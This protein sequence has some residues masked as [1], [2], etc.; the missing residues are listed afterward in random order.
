[1]AFIT[2]REG[3]TPPAQ[4]PARRVRTRTRWRRW[5]HPV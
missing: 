3:T 1:V 5:H 2:A 4:R